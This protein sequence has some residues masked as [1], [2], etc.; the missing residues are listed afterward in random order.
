MSRPFKPYVSNN[1]FGKELQERKDSQSR[2]VQNKKVVEKPFQKSEK[3]YSKH[4]L[5]LESE[6]A[7]KE[8]IQRCI[9]NTLDETGFESSFKIIVQQKT[10]DYQGK[11]I[12][13][14]DGSAYVW[15]TNPEVSCMLAGL[16]QDGSPL[17]K[18]IPDPKFQVTERMKL[19]ERFS[20]VLNYYLS[21]TDFHYFN[22]M[23]KKDC[24][25]N[26]LLSTAE[27]IS[28]GAG[29]IMQ[30]AI[31]EFELD[32]TV[33]VKHL[34]RII[35]ESR[36]ENWAEINENTE[37]HGYIRK[38]QRDF[39]QMSEVPTIEI[40]ISEPLLKLVSYIRTDEQKET[41]LLMD[42]VFKRNKLKS[43]DEIESKAE[44][45]C[46]LGYA[47][48]LYR[49]F[50]ARILDC[51][52]NPREVSFL[53]ISKRTDTIA[54]E[55]APFCKD[56]PPRIEVFDKGNR[57]NISVIFPDEDSASLASFINFN[58]TLN[59]KDGKKTILRFAGRPKAY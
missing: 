9:L 51:K 26:K 40:R 47:Y 42:K 2:R 18:R 17:V 46:S 6:G 54:D 56:K 10:I 59:L 39:K 35:D 55:F 38:L 58:V 43:A 48:D 12:T 52:F 15:F 5:Y 31:K 7:S 30:E 49:K 24:L 37:S 36:K 13:I 27:K 29:Q 4:L 34:M 8:V 22:T 33:L 16:S 21:I 32:E 25:V 20:E 11:N 14:P 41:M 53:E 3:V 23:C 19:A 57:Q 28:S 44:F 45:K 50:E 1:K